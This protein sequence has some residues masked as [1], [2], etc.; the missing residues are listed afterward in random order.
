MSDDFSGVMSAMSSGDSGGST[1]AETPSAASSEPAGA[2]APSAESS[3]LA[4]A[5]ATTESAT[6]TIPDPLEGQAV[7]YVRFREVNEKAK[8]LESTL[9]RYKWAE[10]IPDQAA[11]VITQF[12]QDFTRDPVGTL[13]REIESAAQSDPAHAQSIKSAAARWLGAGRG[14]A[15]AQAEAMPEPDLQAGDGTL[16]YS[17]QQ[18]QKLLDWR[19]RRSQA[20]MA[21]QIQPLQKFAAQQ[22][23]AQMRSEIAA[24]AQQWA[25]S[26]F[27]QWSKRPHFTEYRKEIAGLMEQHGYGVADAYADV[28]TH[29]VLPKLSATERSSVVAQ[30]QQKAAA[31][32]TNPSRTPAQ[33]LPAP[34][35]FA[36]AMRQQMAG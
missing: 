21:Q 34:K 16:V 25:Q 9:G 17:A 8:T 27:S 31:G 5:P 18:A 28:L 33:G 7:P 36:E 23:A 3:A 29:H 12:Y 26:T 15:Q 30:M 6:Q 10:A 20:Q 22:Q 11:P 2:S 4:T 13:L 19:D 35:T 14:Q 1:S 24:N 32:T